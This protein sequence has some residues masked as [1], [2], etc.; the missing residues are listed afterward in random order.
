MSA[1]PGSPVR[2]PRPEPD[3]RLEEPHPRRPPPPPGDHR[4]AWIADRLGLVSDGDFENGDCIAGSDWDCAADN[5]CNWIKDLTLIGYWNFSGSRSG[6]LGGFC[7]GIAT[8]NSSLCQDLFIDGPWLIWYW[9]A[10]INDAVATIKVTVD[11]N[12][13]FSY[14]ADFADHE[15]D[16]QASHFADVSAY[17]GGTHRVCFEYD[18]AADCGANLGDSYFFDFV[19][20]NETTA[21]ATLSFSTVKSLY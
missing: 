15:L 17:L 8:C 6:F 11:G 9:M 12:V 16:Y 19:Q 7:G 10:N 13:E 20:I 14:L 2:R 4:P 21:T 18:N 5:G 3:R 1:R